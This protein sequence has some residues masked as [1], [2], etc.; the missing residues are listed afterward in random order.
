M[1]EIVTGVDAVTLLVV[2]LN[3]ALVAPGFTVTL[4]GTAA[5]PVLL[6]ESDTL[7]PP[8]GAAL[9]SVTT[10]C[11]G[12]PPVTVDGL[13]ARFCRVVDGAAEEVTVSVA[14][15]VAPLYEAV[16][17]TMVLTLTGDVAIVKL[18]VKLFSGAVVVAGTLAT[19]G[20]L[21]D[22]EIAAPP[23]GAPVL[24]TTVPLDALPPTTV[25]GLVEKVDNVGGGGGAS[26]LNVHVA[27]HAPATPA[28]L[29][30]RT[31]QK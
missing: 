15:L 1:A 5:T 9:D 12:E 23:K 11:H 14:V 24:K 22:S 18:A 27:D 10:P 2:A 31:R 16:I 19:F 29:T 28:V 8:A 7:A 17:V 4:D 25:S 30:A 3:T 6:L 20:W 13:S 26:A 21:L